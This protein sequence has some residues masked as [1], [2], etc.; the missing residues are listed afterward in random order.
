MIG[1][2]GVIAL[3]DA[4]KFCKKL[5]FL[6]VSLNEIGPLGFQNICETLL[7]TRIKTL[8]CNQNF[9]NDESMVF[10]AQLIEKLNEGGRLERIDLSKCKI[11]DQGL[12]IIIEALK[13]SKKLRSIRLNE[14]YFS[15]KIEAT[16]LEQ[17]NKNTS[18]TEIQM[19]GVRFSKV[20][21]D[22]IREIT[23][24]NDQM[25][26]SV[27]PDRLNGKINRLRYEK[28]KFD[29]QNQLLNS[30]AQKNNGI[31]KYRLELQ[32]WIGD[33]KTEYESKMKALN[34]E[35][36]ANYEVMEKEQNDIKKMNQKFL[37]E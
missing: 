1:D 6:D 4:L 28:Q 3:M 16:F 37:K 24:R 18:L 29:Q 35:I 7:S 20:C 12:L 10:F 32:E 9:L 36:N 30:Q 8:V 34:K 21:Y 5:K 27:E 25:V 11:N 15:E 19:N 26:R 17:M 14:N 22:K 13:I 31:K 2:H 33:F 23:A